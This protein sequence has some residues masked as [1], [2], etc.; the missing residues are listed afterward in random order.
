MFF[1]RFAKTFACWPMK[2]ILVIQAARFGDLIQ[3]RRLLLSLAETELHL[4]VDA[5]LAPLAALL[6]PFA[7][8]HAL[9]LHGQDGPK[10]AQANAQT[11][12]LLAAERFD[13]V[14][15]LNFSPLT[16]A[17]CRLFEPKQVIGHRPAP[18]S[19]GGFLRS[20]WV[21]TAFGL[22]GLRQATPLNL[23][24]FWAN[25]HESPVSPFVVNPKAAPGGG[26]LGIAVA[27]RE[28]RRSLSPEAL[29]LAAK[30]AF[31][32]LKSPEIRLFGTQAEAARAK[33]TT[34]HFTEAMLAKTIDLCGKTD[35]Q[36][37][38]AAMRGLDLLLTPDTGLMHL[39]AFLGVPTLAFF[40][41]SA[42]AHETGPYGLG[43][44]SI[45]ASPPCAPCLESAPCNQNLVCQKIF[46][47]DSFAR[48]IAQALG[49]APL[50]NWPAAMQLWHSDL[51]CL[52]ARLNLAAGQDAVARMRA[53]ARNYI[54]SGLGLALPKAACAPAW[55]RL[56]QPGQWML[57]P[58]RY[59]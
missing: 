30:T 19:Q 6:Y 14:Y 36:A 46:Q 59:C 10:A 21:R 26:G 52:G 58:W 16:E 48:S 45:Q 51:D 40:F 57:P 37:L 56:Q 18:V 38:L 43:H 25:F 4:A 17:I 50:R 20:P 28:G 55:S 24:D 11:F 8:I 15:N 39:A 53:A 31:Q 47:A 34:K 9:R 3:T 5:A 33:K 42:W 2:K 32:L 49:Q 29:A 13:L 7:K 27:G 54:K 1:E 23:V 12:A 44:I 41:S 22:S 35:W